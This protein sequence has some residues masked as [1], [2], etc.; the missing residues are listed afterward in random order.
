MAAMTGVIPKPGDV[1]RILPAA[2]RAFTD[3]GVDRFRVLHADPIPD[4][5]G[6]CRIRGWD[7]D[8][9]PQ[10]YVGHDV[11]VAGLIIRP[12]ENW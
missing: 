9:D 12:G 6:W 2:A 7:L 1:V 10:V 8:A 5:P 4:R 3:R 11:Q